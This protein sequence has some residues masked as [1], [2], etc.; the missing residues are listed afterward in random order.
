MKYTLIINPTSGNKDFNLVLRH[1]KKRFDGKNLTIY[2][3]TK[4]GDAIRFAKHAGSSDVVIAAGGDGSVNEVINGIMDIPNKKRP[5]LAILPI[6]TSNMVARSLSLPKNIDKAI[7]TILYNRR[8]DIDIGKVNDRYFALA[9]GIGIDAEIYKNVEPKVKKMFGEIA[10]P[11]SFF[12]TIFN[13]KPKLLEVKIN[14]NVYLG[15]YVL[16]CNIAKFHNM[17]E[18]IHDSKDD[19]GLFDVLIFKKKEVG[20]LFKFLF[21]IATKQTHKIQDII[22]LKANNLKITS[23]HDVIAHADA[24]IIGKT[25]IIAKIYEKALEVIC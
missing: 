6:G 8:K 12:K 14:S 19:D 5:R 3:T 24:E 17:L 7:D 1:I 23:H 10:Y 13:Y 16:I 18:I 2:I 4:Q 11:L 22:S 15:Y 20:D 25:P 9:C 21:G